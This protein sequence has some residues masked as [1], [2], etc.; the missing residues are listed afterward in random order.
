MTILL[1]DEIIPMYASFDEAWNTSM[2]YTFS[3]PSLE[4]VLWLTEEGMG[5]VRPRVSLMLRDLHLQTLKAGNTSTLSMMLHRL[6]VADVRD[7]DTG[8]STVVVLHRASPGSASSGEEVTGGILRCFWR[9]EEVPQQDFQVVYAAVRCAGGV[10]RVTELSCILSPFAL[11]V[12]DHFVVSLWYELQDLLLLLPLISGGN[13]TNNSGSSGGGNSS[14]SAGS[15]LILTSLSRH[16]FSREVL[17]NIRRPDSG[18]SIATATVATGT[19]T[20]TPSS[21]T[22]PGTSNAAVPSPFSHAIRGDR[23]PVILF[24]DQARFSRVTLFITFTRHKPDPLWDLLGM[25]TL[26]IPK[27][28]RNMEFTWPVLLVESDATTWGLLQGRV[29]Q[30]ILDGAMRQWTKLTRIG[31]VMDKFTGG[32]HERLE[33]AGTPKPMLP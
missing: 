1:T 11:D 31:K 10:K 13:N 14:T 27:R 23:A 8:P 21:L 32:T 3:A 30:W 12:S 9:G 19:T 6:Q 25:Y 7:R 20:L 26:M 16:A 15:L 4:L 22:A 29:R 24:I 33:L 17:N 2:G 5:N 28:F 18:N